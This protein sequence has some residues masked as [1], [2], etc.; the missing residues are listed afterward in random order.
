MS[1]GLSAYKFI[2]L[3]LGFLHL[4]QSRSITAQNPAHPALFD[5]NIQAR[6]WRTA[7]TGPP[8][9]DSDNGWP[10]YTQGQNTPP[11]PHNE[12]PGTY[13]N[14][15]ADGWTAGFFPDMLWQ[16][17]HR[18]KNLMRASKYANQP[19]FDTWLSY[20][21]QWTDPLIINRNL[22]STHDLGFLAK[23][24]ESALRLDHEEKWL[25]ILRRMSYNL[26]SRF[27]P[28]AGVIRS[29]DTDD[30]Y[31]GTAG[32][33]DDSCLVIID[34]MM[35]LALLAHSAFEYT[36][37]ETLLDIAISHANRTRDSHVRADGSTYHLCDFS[38]NTGELYLCRT[39]QGLADNSTWARGQ[40]W[41]IYGF[42]QMYSFTHDE[43]YLETAMRAADWYIEHLP[44]DGL[45][46]W[47]FNSP[48][49]PSVTP[50]DS[51]SA[52]ITASGLL[53]LQNEIDKSHRKHETH[54]YTDAA[55]QLLDNAIKLSLAGEIFFEDI[56]PRNPSAT[57]GAVTDVATP[58]NT[59]ASDGFESLL[60][61]GTANKNPDAGDGTSY[62][63]G[64]VYGD[65]YLVEAG[66]RLLEMSQKEQNKQSQ[67]P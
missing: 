10:Q 26:A 9:I 37:N 39:A 67:T 13:V 22:T 12:D 34:N 51:S 58:A 45:P 31:F 40:A 19:D 42:A 57:L 2:L 59:S 14:T 55:I 56:D 52:T 35:N 6:I 66:N 24:F 5:E 29:W 32:S 20:A 61:H 1:V 23:P 25:P 46:F 3:L 16:T 8:E 41:A 15:A 53:I 54:N 28:A 50:R 36:H 49:I 4:V 48:S 33:H 43:S 7:L 17:Y 27:V 60:L 65:Y 30:S 11:P 21:K 62:D 44:E 38:A 18:R 47:D 63:T 64:L